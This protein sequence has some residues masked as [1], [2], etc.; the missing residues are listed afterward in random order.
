MERRFFRN[1]H[2]H[3]TQTSPSVWMGHFLWKYLQSVFFFFFSALPNR[4][5]ASDCE[6]ARCEWEHDKHPLRWNRN[7]GKHSKPL[8]CPLDVTD[9]RSW[10]ESWQALCPL[11]SAFPSQDRASMTDTQPCKHASTHQQ[12]KKDRNIDSVHSNKAVDTDSFRAM[13]HNQ[14][15][16]GEMDKH[17][18]GTANLQLS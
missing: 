4:N 3:T 13:G 9:D 11:C 7:T 8:G 6:W 10:S 15:R 12:W 14:Y 17:C 18:D 1:T 5:I 16:G 2:G